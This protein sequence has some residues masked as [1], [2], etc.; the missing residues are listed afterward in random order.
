MR[1][2][3]EKREASKQFS[4][5][6]PGC[7]HAKPKLAVFLFQI[8]DAMPRL[9]RYNRGRRVRRG[10]WLRRGFLRAPLPRLELV[11]RERDELE[12]WPITTLVNKPTNNGPELLVVAPVDSRA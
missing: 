3:F 8:C 4:H 6:L 12:A 9:G 7:L 5:S 2:I 10:R 11:R 1:L